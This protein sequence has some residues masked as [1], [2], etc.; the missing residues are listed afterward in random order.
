MPQ[1]EWV[2]TL[3][4]AE[5]VVTLLAP[6]TISQNLDHALEPGSLALHAREEL[7]AA[8]KTTES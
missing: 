2:A 8:S 5:L 1:T 7:A 4:Q 3:P 6:S